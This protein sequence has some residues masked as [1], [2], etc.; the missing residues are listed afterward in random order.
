MPG[1]GQEAGRGGGNCE[2][3]ER[4]VTSGSRARVA[5]GPGTALAGC[6][7]GAGDTD[8][9]GAA[10]GPVGGNGGGGDKAGG[11]G[12][13]GRTGRGEWGRAGLSPPGLCGAGWQGEGCGK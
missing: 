7:M 5:C 6:G 12:V 4:G 10:S 9:E 8:E 1:R 3:E 13:C 11:S 2:L